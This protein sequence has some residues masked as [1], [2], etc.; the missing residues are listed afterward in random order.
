[1][2]CGAHQPPRDASWSSCSQLSSLASSQHAAPPQLV[3]EFIQCLR[4]LSQSVVPLGHGH[5]NREW[6]LR[7][8]Y[9]DL[10]EAARCKSEN[11]QTPLASNIN[12]CIPLSQPLFLSSQKSVTIT[13]NVHDTGVTPFEEQNQTKFSLKETIIIQVMQET[14]ED[15]VTIQSDLLC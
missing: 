11:P 8:I 2:T 9:C 10:R 14:Q 6:C 13:Q 12:I 7:K 1:M 3:D 4:W 15:L 5:G